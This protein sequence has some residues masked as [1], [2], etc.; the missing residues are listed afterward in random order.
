MARESSTQTRT[1]SAG[2]PTHEQVAER[3]YQIF[4]E[5]GRPEG[6]DQEHWFEAEEQLIAAT[7]QQGGSSLSAIASRSVP[8]RRSNMRS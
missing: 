2:K 5:R 6:R 3:A 8:A 4:V 1:Q 7:Q